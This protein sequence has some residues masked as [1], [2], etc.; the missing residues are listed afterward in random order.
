M[1]QYHLS[2]PR[3]LTKV[4]LTRAVSSWQ[5]TGLSKIRRRK[6]LSSIASRGT[7]ADVR[8]VV[9][10]CNGTISSHTRVYREAGLPKQIPLLLVMSWLASQTSQEGWGRSPPLVEMVLDTFR[11]KPPSPRSD[12]LAL[13]SAGLEDTFCLFMRLRNLILLELS[14]YQIT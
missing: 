1:G 6:L 2:I 3:M 12:Q 10:D 7:T 5:D 14:V 8:S 4:S 11:R 13:V 9:D